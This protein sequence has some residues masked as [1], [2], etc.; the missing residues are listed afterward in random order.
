MRLLLDEAANIAPLADLPQQ[1]SEAGSQ[2]IR[3]ATVWQSLGQM[4]D[5]YHDAADAV[6]ASSTAKLFMGPMT[7]DATRRYL[8]GALG[9]ELREHDHHASWRPKAGPAELQQLERD[10][11]LLINGNLLPAVIRVTPY[12]ELRDLKRLAA[13]SKRSDRWPPARAA[14]FAGLRQSSHATT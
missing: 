11:A 1:L 8:G 9:E 14:A 13:K 4:R 6:L 7:D 12:W 10:R 2:G 5:R 3:F